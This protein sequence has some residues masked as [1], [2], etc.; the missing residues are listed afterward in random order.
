MGSSPLLFCQVTS[1]KKKRNFCEK[2][3]EQLTTLF[4]VSESSRLE[5]YFA[6]TFCSHG[7]ETIYLDLVSTSEPLAAGYHDNDLHP[8]EGGGSHQGEKLQPDM[9]FCFLEGK[10]TPSR[11]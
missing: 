5:R 8:G 2:V 4:R 11:I 6:L 3:P 1:E 10:L 9:F 7:C